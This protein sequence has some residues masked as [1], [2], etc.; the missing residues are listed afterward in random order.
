MSWNEK[1]KRILKAGKELGD[2][3]N[4]ILNCEVCPYSGDIPD[5]DGWT[6][7]WAI[8]QTIPYEIEAVRPEPPD[9]TQKTVTLSDGTEISEATIRAGL[10]KLGEE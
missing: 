6:C 9:T 2:A 4:G 5:D 1:Q 7:Q 8:G 3:C 10:R